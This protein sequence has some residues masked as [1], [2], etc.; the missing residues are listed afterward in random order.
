MVVTGREESTLRLVFSGRCARQSTQWTGQGLSQGVSRAFTCFGCLWHESDFSAAFLLGSLRGGN[1]SQIKS[2]RDIPSVCFR[3][4]GSTPWSRAASRRVSFTIDSARAW[5]VL[6]PNLC[7]HSVRG[8]KRHRIRRSRTFSSSWQGPSRRNPPR[9]RTEHG[10][11]SSQAKCEATSPDLGAQ[12]RLFLVR[13]SVHL[14][15]A[16]RTSFRL[17]AR[18]AS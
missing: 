1:T 15:H 9:F 12:S 17:D 4:G 7:E 6:K 2:W 3:R 13:C 5:C 8:Y 14:S 16:R 11:S 10:F 18:P